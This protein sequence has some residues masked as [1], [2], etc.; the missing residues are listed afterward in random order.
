MFVWYLCY[1]NLLLFVG[2]LLPIMLTNW[3]VL[4]TWI[5]YVFL[6]T[7][8]WRSGML[9]SW[10][11]LEKIIMLISW[12]LLVTWILLHTLISY[13]GVCLIAWFLPPGGASKQCYLMVA[14][15]NC[16]STSHSQI[17]CTSQAHNSHTTVG[18]T[19]GVEQ[20]DYFISWSFSSTKLTLDSWK[21]DMQYLFM[22]SKSDLVWPWTY[23]DEYFTFAIVLAIALISQYVWISL[24]FSWKIF[25]VGS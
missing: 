5:W 24:W 7:K 1:V 10:R 12:C 2:Y 11:L 21:Q 19:Q 20:I 23:V 6:H 16:Q 14:V 13:A 22:S 4:D 18:G 9:L 17:R 3:Y 25:G 15:G 8:I